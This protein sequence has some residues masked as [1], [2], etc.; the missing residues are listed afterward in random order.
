MFLYSRPHFILR[1]LL[2]WIDRFQVCMS[3]SD[4]S[5][6]NFYITI[7]RTWANIRPFP[8]C[9]QTSAFSCSSKP[10]IEKKTNAPEGIRT[11]NLRFRRPTLYP[12]ELQALRTSRKLTC[13]RNL[14][15]DI[16]LHH[17]IIAA[18]SSRGKHKKLEW[19]VSILHTRRQVGIAALAYGL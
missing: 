9:I 18:R 1:W 4:I 19:H 14:L 16:V 10:V 6:M 12:I 11:P 7:Y 15:F 2:P 8:V 13:R 17:L 5:N 3:L